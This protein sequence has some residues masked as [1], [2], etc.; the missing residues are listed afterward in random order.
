MYAWPYCVLTHRFSIVG[1]DRQG[2]GFSSRCRGYSITFS[3]RVK[4]FLNKKFY[5]LSPVLDRCE[6]MRI[7][8]RPW[9]NRL[10]Y[11]FSF[12]L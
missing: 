2:K 11:G 9:W 3:G 7:W 4:L 12:Y 8:M 6:T 1:L 5:Q 10:D